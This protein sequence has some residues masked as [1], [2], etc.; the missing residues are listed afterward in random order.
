[1][2]ASFDTSGSKG[3]AS[4]FAGQL[5]AIFNRNMIPDNPE[6]PRRRKATK[7]GPKQ[8]FNPAIFEERFKSI[9]RIF[10]WEDKFR[11]LL[12]RFER[13]SLVH[14]AFKTLACTMFNLRHCC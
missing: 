9:E 11:R 3:Y 4:V 6:N 10:A 7:R 8:R 5:Q 1:M 13:L 12:L 14:Y 2:P